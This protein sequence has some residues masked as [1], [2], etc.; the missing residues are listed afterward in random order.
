MQE[1]F[2]AP[3]LHFESRR[4]DLRQ[5]AA[6]C[7][8]AVLAGGLAT[9]IAFHLAGKPILHVPI[10]LEQGLN[11]TSTVRLGAGMIAFPR[12]EDHTAGQLAELLNNPRY[13]DAARHFAARY[14]GCSPEAELADAVA[15]LNELASSRQSTE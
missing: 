3:H 5:A 11:A 2:A 12:G 9:T 10:Y 14:A 13:T 4:L 1:A 6:E 15:R 8:L 7:D